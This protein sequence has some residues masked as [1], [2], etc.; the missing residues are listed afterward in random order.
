MSGSGLKT[1]ILNAA[2]ASKDTGTDRAVR[3][4]PAARAVMG[5]RVRFDLVACTWWLVFAAIGA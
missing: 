4:K 1:T 2:A 3:S 5:A